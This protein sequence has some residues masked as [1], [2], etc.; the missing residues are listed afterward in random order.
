MFQVSNDFKQISGACLLVGMVTSANKN[1]HSM[2]QTELRDTL[3]INS[4]K[5]LCGAPV[6]T[7][8][9]DNFSVGDPDNHICG[10]LNRGG[11]IT[12][13]TKL[14]QTRQQLQC[15][16]IDYIRMNGDFYVDL[17]LG[18]TLKPGLVLVEFLRHLSTCRV[19]AESCDVYFARHDVEPRFRLA[20]ETVWGPAFG[21]VN[22]V[23]RQENPLYSATE[24]VTRENIHLLG[25]VSLHRLTRK[26]PGKEG[27]ALP[28]CKL[29][30]R[31]KKKTKKVCLHV[32]YLFNVSHAL[33]V[34]QL[35]NLDV[36]RQQRTSMRSSIHRGAEV[37]SKSVKPVRNTSAIP[38]TSPMLSVTS[39]MYHQYIGQGLPRLPIDERH[40]SPGGN[41]GS[42]LGRPGLPRLPIDERHDNPGGRGGNIGSN[43]TVFF[44]F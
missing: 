44:L 42:K 39:F 36:E 33:D 8:A 13:V 20:E 43:R 9:P 3:R 32:S 29:V 18:S 35:L 31:R 10:S 14:K 1:V 11:A 30:V 22:H 7:L 38:V 2:T 17:I 16:C 27:L 24:R 19:L 25:R 15:I 28:F 41:S 37:R 26:K 4:F 40:D 34:P 5:R 23:T 12:T 6:Y 21:Q